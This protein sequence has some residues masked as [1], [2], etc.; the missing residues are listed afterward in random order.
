MNNEIVKVDEND[1]EIVDQEGTKIIVADDGSEYVMAL[2]GERKM[3]YSS[4]D[5]TKLS[6]KEKAKFFNLV[7]G[8]AKLIKELVNTQIN[9]KDIYMEVVTVE[10]VATHEP[11]K[12]P[13]IVLI[14]D[15][16]LAYTCSSPTFLNKLAQLIAD[17]GEP[18]D[19]ESP[20]PIKFKTVKTNA[21][22][23]ALV[24]E[25]MFK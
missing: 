11:K 1:R 12:L 19:W 15:K 10:D 21:G 2:Q 18:K 22:F 4:I 5:K 9:L 6:F 14:D 16:Q 8:D 25:T 13:R 7:N 17:V 20:I 3:Q 23:Q 24:F